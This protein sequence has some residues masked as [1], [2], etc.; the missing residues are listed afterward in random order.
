MHSDQQQ[1]YTTPLLRESLDGLTLHFSLRDIQSQMSL[2]NPHVLALEYTRLM[3]GFLIYQPKVQSIGMV[4][5]G[6]GSLAKF[7]YHLLPRVKITVVEINPYVIALRSRFQIPNDC[8][9]FEVICEDAASFIKCTAQLFDV[10]L[11]DGF[12]IQGMPTQLCTVQY[13]MDCYSALTAQ[14]VLVV[15]LH[16]CD[17]M[18]NV[19]MG[20]LREVFGDT[21]IQVD[22][23]TGSN[24]IAYC[25][26]SFKSQVAPV[27]ALRN[28]AGIDDDA[29]MSLLPSLAQVY[30]VARE[31]V[32]QPSVKKITRGKSSH[33]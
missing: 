13:Y 14:G 28:Q 4:G 8:D 17:P 5:L 33:G 19:Y 21:V 16:H 9:R 30:L 32:T 6:G 10:L 29:W 7:C 11:L 20:R 27:H 22:D 23:S 2:G 26:K 25:F 31:K 3:M 1:S 24:V 15:N 12:D 18:F